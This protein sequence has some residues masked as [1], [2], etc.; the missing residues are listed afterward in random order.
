MIFA[1]FADRV[2]EFSFGFFSVFASCSVDR[3]VFV[4]YFDDWFC[5]YCFGDIFEVVFGVACPLSA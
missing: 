2:E 3:N 4:S 1:W 5:V